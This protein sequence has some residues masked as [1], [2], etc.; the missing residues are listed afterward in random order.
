M[1]VSYLDWYLGDFNSI[2]FDETTENF[3]PVKKHYRTQSE[4]FPFSNKTVQGKRYELDVYHSLAASKLKA[5]F[6]RSSKDKNL[7][8]LKIF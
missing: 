2:Y 5:L 7:V 4:Y 1:R 6:L 3:S 8:V